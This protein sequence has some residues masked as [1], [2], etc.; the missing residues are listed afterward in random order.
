[1]R[2]Q[3][4]SSTVELACVILV[5]IPIALL[6]INICSLC[7][8]AFINDE[9]S[10]EAARAASQQSSGPLAKYVAEATVQSFSIANGLISSPRV[11][12]VQ[13]RVDYGSDPDNPAP[14]KVTN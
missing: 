7:L 11:T 10:K 1:M 5:L 12:G 13:Y 8:A 4:A 14:T 3:S 2:S 6:A 9:A